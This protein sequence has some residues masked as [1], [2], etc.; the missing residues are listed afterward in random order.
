MWHESN[1]MNVYIGTILRPGKGSN[2][3]RQT[4]LAYLVSYD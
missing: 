4:D 2:A 1:M 3:I